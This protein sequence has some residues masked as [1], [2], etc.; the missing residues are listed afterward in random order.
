MRSADPAPSRAL[1]CLVAMSIAW[2]GCRDED[3]TQAPPSESDGGSD[4]QLGVDAPDAP[5]EVDALSGEIADE[6]TTGDVDV[7]TE[8]IT[9][10]QPTRGESWAM[11]SLHRLYLLTDP[12]LTDHLLNLD[13]TLD[14]GESWI[15][16]LDGWVADIDYQGV[17]TFNWEVPAEAGQVQFR[18]F[19]QA[20]STLVYLSEKVTMTPSQADDGY[21]WELAV[22]PAEFVARDGLGGLGFNGKLW[23]LGGWNPF[24]EWAELFPTTTANDVWSS[25]DGVAWTLELLHAPWEPRHTAGYEVFDGS[26]WILGGDVFMGHY[27]NDVWRSDDGLNW[28]ETTHDAPWGERVLHITQTFNNRL[29]VMGGQTLPPYLGATET[30]FYNDVWSSADGITWT[31][32]TEHANWPARGMG[33]GTTVKDGY[34]WLLGGGTYDTPEFPERLNYNDVW[35][36]ADG[37]HW[38]RLVE[39]APWYSRQY[40]SQVVWDDKLWVM[41]GWS[42]ALGNANDVWYSSDGRNWYEVPET[43][44]AG[45]HAAASMVH[46]GRLWMI[47]GN[48]MESDV[49]S[50]FDATP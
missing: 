36:T 37:I 16:Y 32:E 20:E 42:P 45:R 13:Y 29:W 9:W 49:W 4:T 28:T 18:A 25:T 30:I 8:P 40:H 43:P 27:Q 3:S 17:L 19:D 38:E 21:A 6:A 2:I 7:P 1:F 15:P 26:M 35:R 50:L 48:N 33:Y 39:R 14:G 24:P 11:G 12:S 5:I 31:L 41:Q 44:W 22:N 47:A 23:I 34:M 46:N 10:L